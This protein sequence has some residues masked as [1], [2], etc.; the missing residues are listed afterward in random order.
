MEEQPGHGVTERPQV[1]MSNLPN[2]VLL[3]IAK[4]SEQPR[5]MT[6]LFQD[7]YHRC[8]VK[9]FANVATEFV[10]RH[11]SVHNRHHSFLLRSILDKPQLALLVSKLSISW[12]DLSR[13]N[14]D[15]LERSGLRW[16]I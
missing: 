5:K 7:V 14:K 4:K 6:T 1:T 10:Y 2:E 13:G 16:P 11:Y 12:S 15:V 9:P 8:L 3:Y